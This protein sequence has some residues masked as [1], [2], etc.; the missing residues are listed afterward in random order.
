MAAEMIDFTHP[1]IR[2]VLTLKP[3]QRRPENLQRLLQVLD[4]GM[5]ERQP[6]PP[7]G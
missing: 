5:I 7:R 3:S 1:I 4:A 6:L 2:Q